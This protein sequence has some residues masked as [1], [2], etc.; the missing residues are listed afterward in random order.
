MEEGEAKA[1]MGCCRRSQSL[2][3]GTCEVLPRRASV[4]SQ[5]NKGVMRQRHTSFSST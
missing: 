5:L 3:A 2:R 1:A 4:Q